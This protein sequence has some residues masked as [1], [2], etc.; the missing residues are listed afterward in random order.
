MA[1]SA[2]TTRLKALY[3]LPGMQQKSLA[4]AWTKL[5]AGEQAAQKSLGDLRAKRASDFSKSAVGYLK[6]RDS[7]TSAARIRAFVDLSRM[8][9]ELPIEYAKAA[10]LPNA[11]LLDR[12]TTAIDLAGWAEKSPK[13]DDVSRKA[14]A[15][16]LKWEKPEAGNVLGTYRAMVKKYGEP[17]PFTPAEGGLLDNLN[18]IREKVSVEEKN[19]GEFEG[20]VTSYGTS[21]EKWL[22]ENQQ[23]AGRED[24]DATFQAFLQDT[25][26]TDKDIPAAS[27]PFVKNIEDVARNPEKNPEFFSDID[28]DIAES[29]KEQA[30]YEEL[31]KGLGAGAVSGQSE[32]PTMRE[33]LAG[34]VRRPE[35]R[36]WAE[37]YGFELG[38]ATP[39][40]P[41]SP[42][43]KDVAAG[44]YPDKVLVN[45]M[46]Y[47]ARPD[48]MRAF[49]LADAQIVGDPEDNIL[50]GIGLARKAGPRTMV[51]IEEIIGPGQAPILVKTGPGDGGVAVI[52]DE[53]NYYWTTD[54]K[55][56]AP[57]NAA[58][59]QKI[60]ADADAAGTTEEVSV[61]LPGAVAKPKTRT[62]LAEWREPI[63]GRKTDVEGSTRFVDPD[64]KKERVL[65][66]E[67]QGK[68]AF[69]PAGPPSKAT[70]LMQRVNSASTARTQKKEGYDLS[71]EAQNQEVAGPAPTAEQKKASRTATDAMRSGVPGNN[72]AARVG[73]K[74]A[75]R[76]GANVERLKALAET[77]LRVGEQRA[78]RIGEDAKRL[79]ALADV[80][81]VRD[82]GKRHF[83]PDDAQWRL[84]ERAGAVREREARVRGEADAAQRRLFKRADAVREREA[85]VRA[86]AEAARDPGTP[87]MPI[88]TSG[89]KEDLS[90][91]KVG[92]SVIVYENEDG[93]VVKDPLAGLDRALASGPKPRWSGDTP[94]PEDL[95]RLN[96][97]KPKEP[98]TTPRTPFSDVVTAEAKDVAPGT[99]LSGM[100]GGTGPQV[101]PAP[102]A[103]VKAG[104]TDGASD[105]TRMYEQTAAEKQDR[106]AFGKEMGD[107][108]KA[109]ERLAEA[110]VTPPSTITPTRRTAADVQRDAF[111]KGRQRR[112]EAEMAA[113]AER[114]GSTATGSAVAEVPPPR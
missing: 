72:R 54:G 95:K 105:S 3:K 101:Q 40:D 112:R 24:Q 7:G 74:Q 28:A 70:S 39:V 46:L 58:A 26:I 5:A 75:D 38:T 20:A 84:S 22:R 109:V 63:Y 79:E 82:V 45:G 21:W 110:G 107:R 61:P 32:D 83:V 51:E 60:M 18:A 52:D 114:A 25:G 6:S 96:T 2:E 1:D 10:T 69:F 87:K 50:R 80:T 85:R 16:Y 73:E 86:E 33:F 111:L 9:A 104:D 77:Q 94:P 99:P 41:N 90:G 62:I 14:W 98:W 68:P 59:G 11:T 53:G 78:D 15:E 64:T 34:W 56:Y 66:K 81:P 76:I 42:L 55:T 4:D 35:V 102:K 8:R 31:L 57:I 27:A 13:D 113:Q 89:D 12:V 97:L 47:S 71:D 44:R 43:G 23:Y 91:K 103:K 19:Y 67:Q 88:L 92:P 36:W 106:A 108:S 30:R 17:P 37:K 93:V 49:R 48:D 65:T 100:G 29:N